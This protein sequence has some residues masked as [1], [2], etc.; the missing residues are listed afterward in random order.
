MFI[1]DGGHPAD[2]EED[3][4]VGES[5]DEGEARGE[6]EGDNAEG[7]EEANEG[8]D[9][10]EGTENEEAKNNSPEELELAWELLEVARR[11]YEDNPGPDTDVRLAELY[12][13][14]GDVQRINNFYDDA[15]KEYKRGL[16]ICDS[17]C[18]A[19]DRYV[20]QTVLIYT[21]YH[22]LIFDNIYTGSTLTSTMQSPSLIYTS[23]LKRAL[24]RPSRSSSPL[25]ATLRLSRYYI[26]IHTIYITEF[27][28]II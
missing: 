1:K 16:E 23:V 10:N 3:E 28:M 19:S 5:D 6:V 25:R 14:L 24:T 4:E 27:M 8:E 18:K 13:R 15:I 12:V 22:V 2:L 26:Y 21:C 7:G 20:M 11:I 17:I 9:N